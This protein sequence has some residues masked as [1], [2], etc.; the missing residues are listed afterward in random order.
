MSDSR[1]EDASRDSDLI[2]RWLDEGDKLSESAHATVAGAAIQKRR[3]VAEAFADLRA[4]ADRRRFT[5]VIGAVV[6]AAIAV[7]AMRALSHAVLTT[8]PAVAAEPPP[9]AAAPQQQPPTPIPAAPPSEPPP[10]PVAAAAP[11][12]EPPPA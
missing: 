8:D 12:P 9:P 4:M 10:V 6:V 5:F 11:A 2:D 3:R 1:L 7:V